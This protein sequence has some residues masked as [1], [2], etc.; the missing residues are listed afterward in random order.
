MLYKLGRIGILSASNYQQLFS[1]GDGLS[2]GELRHYWCKE[3]LRHYLAAQE[4]GHEMKRL[5][6]LAEELHRQQAITEWLCAYQQ[7]L[8]LDMPKERRSIIRYVGD[9]EN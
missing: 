1:G 8:P 7:E 6:A 9:N 3:F 2:Y 5:Y 4:K